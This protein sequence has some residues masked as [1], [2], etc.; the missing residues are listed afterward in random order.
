MQSS[1][2]SSLGGVPSNPASSIRMPANSQD[3]GSSCRMTGTL[4]TRVR[5]RV[6]VGVGV[7]VGTCVDVRVGV[8]GRGVADGFGVCV[9]G[10]GVPE[11]VG[12]AVGSG[13]QEA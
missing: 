4:S 9:E 6:E 12:I 3:K 10:T 7:G 1:N 5:S 11:D 13:V 2:C 8:G